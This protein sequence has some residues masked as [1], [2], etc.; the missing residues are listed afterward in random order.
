MTAIFA[1]LHG[2]FFL[3]RQMSLVTRLCFHFAVRWSTERSKENSETHL[4]ETDPRQVFLRRV[5]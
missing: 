3:V 1:L 2:D 5:T 4:D